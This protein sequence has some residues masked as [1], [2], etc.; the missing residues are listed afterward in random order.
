ME[1]QQRVKYNFLIKMDKFRHLLY[2]ITLLVSN[3]I[4]GQELKEIENFGSNPGNLKLF[5]Y[6]NKITT[7]NKIP[8]VIVLHGCN[9]NASE[10]AELTGWNKLADLYQFKVIYPQQKRINNISNCFN[11][12]QLK[13]IEKDKGEGESI[14]QM[15]Q[16]AIKNYNIDINNI[17]ITGLSAGGAM[18]L[19]LAA[20]HPE[21]FKSTAVFAGGA[22][23]ITTNPIEALQIM[24][25][26]YKKEYYP[27]LYPRRDRK[28]LFKRVPN[29]YRAGGSLNGH[30][31]LDEAGGA[32]HWY[33]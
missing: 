19:V 9:Q 6:D 14:Y 28:W 24:N 20:T 2:G 23:K 18:S 1:L 33:W 17:H 26:N 29:P 11:W 8:L 4:L 12:F 13:D 21:T 3:I 10:I 16:I 22:Y 7:K 30:S 31:S 5:V 27:C 32:S 15:I 25:G